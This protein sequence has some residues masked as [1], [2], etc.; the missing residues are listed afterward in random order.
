MGDIKLKVRLGTDEFDGE[1]PEEIITKQYADFLS[2]RMTAIPSTQPPKQ[3]NGVGE[4]TP[5]INPEQ[6]NIARIA[7]VEGR[8]VILTALPQGENREIDAALLL[9]V[10]YRILRS[11][12]LVSADEMLG[13]LKQSGLPLDR[14]DRLMARAEAQG[15]ITKTG[16]RRGVKYRL[17][18]P[19]LTRAETLARELASVVA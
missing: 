6:S 9:L 2:A 18:Q 7:R 16:I 10:G 13:G 11:S 8:L 12:E 3:P 5:P 15:L 4:S 1:G 17:T 14:A 19:G